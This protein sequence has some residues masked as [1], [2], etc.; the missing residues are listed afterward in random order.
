[1]FNNNC[2]NFTDE[3]AGLLLGTGIPKDIVD[4]PREFLNTP[5]GQQFAPMMQ[6]MQN[7]LKVSSN[8]LFNESGD[9][10]PLQTRTQQPAMP[11][12]GAGPGAGAAAGGMPDMSQLANMA[13]Q[14]GAGGNPGAAGGNNDMANMLGNMA[15]NPAV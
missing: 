6:N 3:C 11:Q 15:N 14:M 13:Q 12:P 9:Q 4:L 8:S 5:L 2:N 1:M 10:Q 7:S